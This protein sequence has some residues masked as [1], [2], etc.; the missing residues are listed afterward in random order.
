MIDVLDPLHGSAMTLA[1]MI[2][3]KEISPVELMRA[4]L[5]RIERLQPEL[6][7]FITICAD[8]AMTAARRAED[9]VMS[10][11]EL[12][13]AHGLP[14][15]AKDMVNTK[16]VRTT[17]GSL[18][19]KDN[20]PAK[21]DLAVARMKAAGA[22]LVG[23]TTTP[24]FAHSALTQSPLFGRTRNAWRADR[25]SGGSSG[26]G[27]VALAAGLTL[28]AIETDSG[29]S[30][31]IPASCNGL[32]GLKQT[33]GLIPDDT[34][35]DVFNSLIAV[36]P[37]AKT[38]EDLAFVLDIISGR[39]Q[40]DPYSL[41]MPPVSHPDSSITAE[42]LHGQRIA[43]LPP[44]DGCPIDPDVKA[45]IGAVARTLSGL[46]ASIDDD[47][48]GMYPD[49]TLWDRERE[50]WAVMQGSLRLN[51]YAA[52]IRNSRELISPSFL[53]LV[54]SAEG[55]TIESLQQAL[56]TR[57][58]IFR[59]VQEWFDRYDLVIAPTLTR[60]A[61]SIDQDLEEPFAIDREVVTGPM[62]YWYPH[63]HAFNLSGHPSLTVPCGF[64]R[65]GMPIGL[66]LIGPWGSDA[67]LLRI[68]T[69]IEQAM[70]YAGIRPQ[71]DKVA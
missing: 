27:A 44:L 4:T 64:D 62:K 22:I 13:P 45:A 29:G 17:F 7:C 30:V 50:A 42:S 69:M 39:D 46:Q 3:R 37:M 40:R 43:V 57:S 21:D 31:R 63:T 8:E 24:E 66:Q 54:E 56:F 41:F 20:I 59:S 49:P 48:D 19:L 16:G 60:T 33:S 55:F 32:V 5:Q 1:G 51:R 2:R 70:G 9:L 14:F 71:F 6:N 38:A 12:G 11:A 18:V 53:R 36:T 15:T 47:P 34:S 68:A 58:A 52:S 35:L 10:G 61:L 28:M 67:R 23:K 65:C 26:G 25:T